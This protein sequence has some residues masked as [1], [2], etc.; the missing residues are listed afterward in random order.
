MSTPVD[1]NART[2]LGAFGSGLI[3]GIGNALLPGQPFEQ[4][5]YGANRGLLDTLLLGKNETFNTRGEYVRVGGNVRTPGSRLT[6]INGQN[7]PGKPVTVNQWL[8]GP[9]AIQKQQKLWQYAQTGVR[10]MNWY[11]SNVVPVLQQR[12]MFAPAVTYSRHIST[13]SHPRSITYN[14]A[15]RQGT[16]RATT[17]APVPMQDTGSYTVAGN[18]GTATSTPELTRVEDLLLSDLANTIGTI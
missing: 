11:K 3:R 18:D 2:G 5:N 15:S 16:F 13:D 6:P 9:N 1:P 4:P 7:T 17:S 12:G 14:K 8:Q 10:Q